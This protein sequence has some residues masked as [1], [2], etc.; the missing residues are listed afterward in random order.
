MQLNPTPNFVGR[1]SVMKKLLPLAEEALNGKGKIVF[2]SGQAGV[3]KTEFVAQALQSKDSAIRSLLKEKGAIC[4]Y[5]ICR[6]VAK[7]SPTAYVPFL[8]LFGSLYNQV[9]E[10]QSGDLKDKALKFVSTYKDLAPDVLNFIPGVGPFIGL[11]V[12]AGFATF[13]S[14]ENSWLDPKF[15]SL[16]GKTTD[17]AGFEQK[18]IDSIVAVAKKQPFVM[19][20]DDV[21]WAD[22]SSANLI[23]HLSETIEK[24]PV[25][26]LANL[27][28]ED[29]RIEKRPIL[30][31]VKKIGGRY[32][33][34]SV[35]EVENLSPTAIQA[36]V[37][38]RF[39]N[40]K[41][42]QATK[43]E[44][45]LVEKTDGNP[46]FM[47]E[48][49]EYAIARLSISHDGSRIGDFESLN[50]PPKS[51][52]VLKE[53]I[54]MLDEDTRNI[55]AYA[56]VQGDEFTV[57]VLKAYLEKSN[58][59]KAG[60]V[61]ELLAR[62]R[63]THQVVKKL[64]EEMRM[65]QQTTV[66]Q[67]MSKHLQAML[68]ERLD[69]EQRKP[70]LDLLLEMEQHYAQSAEE[71]L[72]KTL[73]AGDRVVF[74][75]MAKNYLEVARESIE[76]ARANERFYA[77]QEILLAC[78][79][80]LA[81]L[82]EVKKGPFDKNEV[83]SLELQLLLLQGR[84]YDISS[85]NKLAE[86]TYSK[87]LAKAKEIGDKDRQAEAHNRLG[88]YIWWRHGGPNQAKK[89]FDAALDLLLSLG[90]SADKQQLA[91]A[92]IGKGFILGRKEKTQA[93]SRE[94]FEEALKIYE[95][96]DDPRG[97]ATCYHNI[98]TTE[99]DAAKALRW[100]EKAIQL[101]EQYN[102]PAYERGNTY[103]AIAQIYLQRAF[104]QKSVKLA[105][106]ALEYCDKS[107]NAQAPVNDSHIN[108]PY[109]IQ[110]R[111]LMGLGRQAQ[112]LLPLLKCVQAS[113]STKDK[114]WLALSRQ[115]AIELANSL[116]KHD[117]VAILA[118]E[119]YEALAQF[120]Q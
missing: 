76:Q 45:W 16:H 40:L 52:S 15:T 44:Q 6:S 65:G 25:L 36:F 61:S 82:E 108:W 98:G 18:V 73:R 22:P 64:G 2:I 29:A 50:I 42:D 59:P 97:K 26:L 4:A 107:I 46:L 48:Y 105:E 81:G 53:R 79:K 70:I 100:Y 1:L 12:K 63:D 24:L 55:L 93:D 7:D 99:S 57:Y 13:P 96:I 69:F 20:L 28:P 54:E 83:A 101:S 39:P 37:Q 35:L 78:T 34:S 118:A 56:S 8:Q 14:N 112:S 9:S 17:I 114:D 3:G 115:E 67:F 95:E 47:T 33:T 109:F 113:H 77:A 111:A 116:E 66:Y 30:D 74:A 38:K 62:A 90:E 68:S 92:Y 88:F 27:R 23:A 60:T 11:I 75:E 71:S 72:A 104:D 119:D 19:F 80:G 87:A 58:N 84:G 32:G 120:L 94:C 10:S 85:K 51:E 49:L 110:Y 5:S 91:T 31:V 43:L 41:A 102:L 103:A 86:D 106:Q 89:Q 21:H 117:L